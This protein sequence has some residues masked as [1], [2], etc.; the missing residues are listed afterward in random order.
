MRVD[1]AAQNQ[2]SGGHSIVRDILSA[3]GRRVVFVYGLPPNGLVMDNDPSV[4]YLSTTSGKAPLITTAGH[5]FVESIFL[6]HPDLKE[7]L[8]KVVMEQVH[9][10]PRWKR[11]ASRIWQT[12]N[13][14]E[15][16]KEDQVER[17]TT[18]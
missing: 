15:L 6:D 14:R 18:N 11:R 3:L 17:E 5:E 10:W 4:I 9:N 2:R 7:R 1:F 13:E 12:L 16:V 8:E